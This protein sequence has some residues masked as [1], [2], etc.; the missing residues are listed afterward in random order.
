M[1]FYFGHR[2]SS[3]NEMTVLLKFYWKTGASPTKIQG[4][5][6]VHRKKKNKKIELGLAFFFFFFSFFFFFFFFCQSHSMRRFPGQG[7]HLYHNSSRSH[8]SDTRSFTCFATREFL[9]LV[10][11]RVRKKA[12]VKWRETLS[13]TQHRALFYTVHAQPTVLQQS[14][15]A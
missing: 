5:S 7:L 3:S 10:S 11:G 14:P 6:T 2:E 1:D 9:G 8:S 15:R 12:V 13:S 4:G